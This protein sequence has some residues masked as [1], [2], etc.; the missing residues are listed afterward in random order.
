MFSSI[1]K[2]IKCLGTDITLIT[3]FILTFWNNLSI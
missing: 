2:H 3:L 1:E